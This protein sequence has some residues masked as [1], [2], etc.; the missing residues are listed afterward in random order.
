[1]WIIADRSFSKDRPDRSK[2]NYLRLMMFLRPH[3]GYAKKQLKPWKY[4][5]VGLGS[6]V[7]PVE[8]SLSDQEEFNYTQE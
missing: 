8:I 4:R 1:M 7:G 6:K 5:L 2:G 3:T